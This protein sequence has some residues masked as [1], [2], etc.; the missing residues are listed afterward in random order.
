MKPVDPE[1]T[2][3]ALGNRQ[4]DVRTV[5]R[6]TANKFDTDLGLA[7][8]YWLKTIQPYIAGRKLYGVEF[9]IAQEAHEWLRMM[10]DL[11]THWND[12]EEGK[13]APIP[14][15]MFPEWENEKFHKPEELFADENLKPEN[16]AEIAAPLLIAERNK[17]SPAEA[18]RAAHDLLMVVWLSSLA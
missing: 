2:E 18:V 4:I 1:K 12:S 7:R 6:S 9:F 10:T 17:M 14:A 16:L 3:I 15:E 11:A 13:K 8:A 5:W